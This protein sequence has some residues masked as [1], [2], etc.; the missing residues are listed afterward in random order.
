MDP[1][2]HAAGKVVRH[3]PRHQ[4]RAAQRPQT[5]GRTERARRLWSQTIRTP[6]RRRCKATPRNAGESKRAFATSS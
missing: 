5:G 3:A 2:V 4:A 6:R 1:P